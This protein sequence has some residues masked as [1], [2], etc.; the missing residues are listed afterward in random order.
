MTETELVRKIQLDLSTGDVRLFRNNVGRLPD[1]VV[2]NRY[3]HYGLCV[4]SSDLIGLRSVTIT[5]QM[6]GR[7]L[8]IF[9][10][11]EAKSAKGRATREQKSFIETVSS[12]GALAGIARSID[13]ARSILTLS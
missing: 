10:A 13:E 2:P 9:T 6:V 4:G 1:P 7:R 8:A 5:S 12:L 11:I 3:I